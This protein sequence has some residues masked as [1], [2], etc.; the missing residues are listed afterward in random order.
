MLK[1]RNSCKDDKSILYL[2][3][4]NS[5]DTKFV[6][7]ITMVKYAP[8]SAHSGMLFKYILA[9]CLLVALPVQAF[10]K[11]L[12][13]TRI[14]GDNGL[15]A[16]NVK[17]ITQDKYGFMWFGTKNGLDRYDGKQ[18]KTFYIY[19]YTIGRGDQ[20]VGALLVDDTNKLWI[21]TDIGI[22]IFDPLNERFTFFDHK[23][24]NGN[25][26]DNW[27]ADI[28]KDQKGNIW[29]VIPGQNVFKYVPA[30]DKLTEYSLAEVVDNRGSPQSIFI[31]E[32]NEV[33]VGTN[34]KG[35]FRYDEAT[36]SFIQYLTDKYGNSLCNRNV[37]TLCKYR[38]NMVIGI[39]EGELLRWDMEN[40]SLK[41][42]NTPQV[43]NQ[44]IRKVV[45]YH[46]EVLLIA[47]QSGLFIYNE[48]EQTLIN[49]RED[50]LNPYSLSDNRV[51]SVYQDREQGIWLGTL[52]GGV[53]YA[54]NRSIEFEKYVPLSTPGSLSTK[55]IREL[56]EDNNGHIWIGTENGG[57]NIYD[58]QENRFSV[59]SGTNKQHTNLAI[60]NDGD[61]MLVGYF[62]R[63]L[64]VVRWPSLYT[65]HY[66]ERDL[67]IS[68]GSVCSLLKDSKGDYWLGNAAELY[69]SPNL[70]RKFTPRRDLGNGYV[71][72]IQEDHE[73]NIWIATLGNG[74]YSYNLNTGA[75]RHYLHNAG[76]SLSLSSNSVSS[77]TVDS[78]G[79]V[80][81]STDRGGICCYNKEGNH[82]TGYS[83]KDGL[84]DDVA[85]KIL[86]DKHHNLWF[87][88]NKGL[89][90]F[91]P[92]TKEVRVFTKSD[93]LLGN[94]FSYKSALISRSGKF[95]FGG[96][97]GL[98][99]FYPDHEAKNGEEPPIFITGMHIY[100]KEVLTGDAGSPLKQSMLH[101]KEIRLNYNQSNVSFDYAAL[102]YT[103]PAANTFA[104]KMEGIDRDW[105]HTRN[106]TAYYSQLPPGKYTFKV[107][108]T[109]N[110]GV[111]NAKGV[112]LDLIIAPPWWKSVYAY[113]C[114]MLLI[115]S[116]AY[117]SLYA[118][119]KKKE[120]K[121]LEVRKLFEIRKEHELY[122][123][124]V[125]FFTSI[126]HEIKTPLSLIKGPLEEVIKI[127]TDNASQKKNLHIMEL[128]TNR[129]LNLI[130]QLLDF[131]KIDANKVTLYY[132][133][134]NITEL[135]KETALRFEPSILSKG[136][137]LEIVLT[138]K[139]LFAPI[140]KEAV[141]KILSNLL[142]NALKY[143]QHVI[144]IVVMEETTTFSIHV[145]SDGNPI[146]PQVRKKIFEP[147]YQLNNEGGTTSGVGIGLS[148]ATSLAELHSGSLQLKVDEQQH[149]DF[150]LSLP[151]HQ[152]KVI[153]I[154]NAQKEEE[155]REMS[156][157]AENSDFRYTVL[158]VDDNKE[159]LYFIADKLSSNFEIKTA[160]HGQEAIER[161]KE[162]RIHAIISDVMMPVMDGLELCK[163]VKDKI[164]YS[165]IPFIMLTARNDL[166][167]KL[168]GLE[169]GADAYLEKPFSFTFLIAQVSNLLANR[170]K[171]RTAFTQRP[172]FPTHNTKM[173]RADE[174]YLEKM[175]E[176]IH[177]NIADEHFNV[178]RLA[179]HL[180]ISR[181]ALH[182]KIKNLTNMVPVDFIR[183]IR[184]KRAAELI[185][186][187]KYTIAE[188]SF[189]VGINSPS[190]FSKLFQKQFGVTP[191]AFSGKQAGKKKGK[192][193]A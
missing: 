40:N 19:D 84:P 70:S 164:E 5:A 75:H 26:L 1:R 96:I 188:I 149:N 102:S 151:L 191:R 65:R 54:A 181:S 58:P 101:T 163:Y 23:A 28:Q 126:A 143:A 141:T 78:H 108:G 91:N 119:N 174:E 89:V 45:S 67:G 31:S 136:K 50:D 125:D 11:E 150:V 9:V 33:W 111:W 135:I 44:I 121:S 129:L 115:V 184:L 109:N 153:M 36:N 80:W 94:Q 99:A 53:N 3:F 145:I 179:E 180:H 55:K 142:N 158:V 170:E 155:G 171:E 57:I 146:P 160:Q 79:K 97:D 16:N 87:G 34:G 189:M 73:Q 30:E 83:L 37:F 12:Y 122:R 148:L 187:G 61:R 175:T 81:F 113:V 71:Y 118:Y 2:T 193:E 27:V 165:H 147:F 21:G 60:Y 154:E 68:E 152:E 88:T 69:H 138:E 56:C 39:H 173:N 107:K 6:Y 103:A 183:V 43:H 130:N 110:D 92:V 112:S 86:E 72:D 48:A 167:S 76:D 17:S 52:L 14:N 178:E 137:E 29:I 140:D 144:K 162:E 168:K 185:Q 95:Y 42:Y 90:K 77:I 192:S 132:R 51:Y 18:I 47:T 46:P 117:Y 22:F 106:H 176:L 182:R 7:S 49:C 4:I 104:Y 59:P 100:N 169:I 62:K 114:Y 24:L 64:D 186:E 20:N 8:P 93:G 123:A 15:S 82:F 156:V 157:T 41:T 25:W 35:I 139:E 124:K 98:I 13:F 74:V 134:E 177:A 63:A 10:A 131:R 172:F 120:R 159:L 116:I 105:I 66:S 38:G 127:D 161:L 85:Y 190:Y 133:Y 166:E 128:N 32:T